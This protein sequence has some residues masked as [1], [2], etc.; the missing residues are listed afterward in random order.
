MIVSINSSRPL[1]PETITQASKKVT[2]DFSVPDA[3]QY[4]DLNRLSKEIVSKV[5]YIEWIIL[6]N[7]LDIQ[8]SHECMPSYHRPI[9]GL[10]LAYYGY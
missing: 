8:T 2:M 7:Q 10:L 1:W 3:P 9:I 5:D 4:L 6:T